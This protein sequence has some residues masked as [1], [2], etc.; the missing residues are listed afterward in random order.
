MYA[1]SVQLDK[2]NA[3]SPTEWML[4][5]SA[6]QQWSGKV[7]ADAGEGRYRVYDKSV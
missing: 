4:T 2:C 7:T 1:R 5:L 6:S 3:A